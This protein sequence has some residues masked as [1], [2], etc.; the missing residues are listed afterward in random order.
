[1]PFGINLAAGALAML[2]ATAVSALASPE[3]ST[4]LAVVAL[5][6]FGYAVLVDD[7]RAVF[8]VAGIGY[9]L[10]DGFLVNR[11]GDLTWEGTTSLG[12]FAL[13][14]GAGAAVRWLR[15]ARARARVSAEL[16]DLLRR[17]DTKESHR[18]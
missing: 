4:G 13:A 2:G 5:T 7:I 9:L 12:V 14:V 8:A 15:H 18:A 3:R 17:T 16:D 6:V 11:Y 1:V 10:Y